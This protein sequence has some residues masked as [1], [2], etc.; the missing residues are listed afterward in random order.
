MNMPTKDNRRELRGT[1]GMKYEAIAFRSSCT[2]GEASPRHEAGLGA[3]AYKVGL[4][5]PPE[6]MEE[7]YRILVDR[8][9]TARQW[10]SLQVEG[11][12]VCWVERLRDLAI[13][14][15]DLVVG[16]LIILVTLP[17]F[18]LTALLVKGTSS[19]PILY[20]QVRV[21]KHGKLFTLYKFRTMVVSEGKPVVDYG[22]TPSDPRVTPIGRTLRMTRLDELPQFFSVVK[23]DMSLV[24]PRPERPFQVAR[25]KELQRTR[26]SVKPG[27][28]G[29][30]QIRELYE[31]KPAHKIKYDYL[32]I[33]NRSLP[34]N[35]YILLRSVP[36]LFRRR[37]W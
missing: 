37:G 5:P 11:A 9:L 8:T 30:A 16:V 34:L 7:R 10:P 23:G 31:L 24:G 27:L 14:C 19:G 2:A 17:V 32:Y 15:L 1:H 18:L 6:D 3:R 21:G 36:A 29:L 28:T 20:R 26:L 22:I 35:I 12:R 33:Q 25:H 4:V 13:R